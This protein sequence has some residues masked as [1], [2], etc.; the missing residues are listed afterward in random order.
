MSSLVLLS[1]ALI[2]VLPCF[3]TPSF[4]LFNQL[5]DNQSFSNFTVSSSDAFNAGIVRYHEADCDSLLV[6]WMQGSTLYYRILYCHFLYGKYS[7]QSGFTPYLFLKEKQHQYAISLPIDLSFGSRSWS[8]VSNRPI[9]RA[10]AVADGHSGAVIGVAHCGSFVSNFYNAQSCSHS[11]D[12]WG[13]CPKSVCCNEQGNYYTVW[14][15]CWTTCSCSN[16]TFDRD[17]DIFGR[18]H[19]RLYHSIKLHE[20]TVGALASVAGQFTQS[21]PLYHHIDIPFPD[22]H[23]LHANPTLPYIHHVVASVI[24][25]RDLD[26]DG[27]L[28]VVLG[29]VV[30]E[31]LHMWTKTQPTRTCCTSAWGST[32][33]TTANAQQILS[34]W[35]SI[36]INGFNRIDD[37]VGASGWLIDGARLV[38]DGGWTRPARGFVNRDNTAFQTGDGTFEYIWGLQL[39]AGSFAHGEAGFMFNM[40]D[41]RNFYAYILDNHNACGNVR[42]NY[43]EVLVKV[44]NGAISHQ[45]HSPIPQFAHGQRYRIRIEKVFNHIVVYRDGVRVFDWTDPTTNIHTGTYGFYVWDQRGAYFEDIKIET[46]VAGYYGINSESVFLGS[47]A[48]HCMLRLFVGRGSSSFNRI[49]SWTPVVTDL[50][51]CVDSYTGPLSCTTSWVNLNTNPAPDMIIY[52]S[53]DEHREYYRVGYDWDLDGPTHWGTFVSGLTALQLSDKQAKMTLIPVDFRDYTP[54]PAVVQSVNYRVPPLLLLTQS[55]G[56]LRYRHMWRKG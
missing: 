22:E 33:I 39:D 38:T 56:V 23:P 9:S 53:D 40:R 7:T 32:T 18:C 15:N 21:V 10:M 25:L 6:A 45:V 55:N 17:R 13:T 27:F 34:N 54:T 24:A 16:S 3:G 19:Y 12:C 2:C 26:G 37:L 20:P 52:C 8:Q 49:T 31:P 30:R 51:G 43:A 11:W 47:T 50:P 5:S 4:N 29:G 44:T 28:D 46:R 41:D 48:R 14:V 42:Y 1:L 36:T 35:R